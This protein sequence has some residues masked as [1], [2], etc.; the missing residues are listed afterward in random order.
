[1]IEKKLRRFMNSLRRRA[2]I[3]FC[4]RCCST[5]IDATDLIRLDCRACGNSIPPGTV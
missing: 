3:I 2:L 4:V 5:S 1:M